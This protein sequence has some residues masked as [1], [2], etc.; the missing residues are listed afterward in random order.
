MASRLLYDPDPDTFVAEDL[1]S[2]DD[3]RRVCLSDFVVIAL[4]IGIQE[5][6]I[7]AAKVDMFENVYTCGAKPCLSRKT[8]GHPARAPDG[9]I[10]WHN[11]R[12]YPG[13]TGEYPGRWTTENVKDCVG[14]AD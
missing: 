11:E 8:E 5:G 13:N 3:M 9:T 7:R 12:Q 4:Q 6:T 1:L 2:R 10:M 14:Y